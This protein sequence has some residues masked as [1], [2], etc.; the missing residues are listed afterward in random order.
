MYNLNQF[1]NI[2]ALLRK[3]KGWTQTMFAEKLGISPQAISKWECGIGYPDV[4]LFPIIAELL[5]VP[6]GVIF[7]EETQIEEE[8]TMEAQRIV[9][10]YNG[11]FDICSHIKIYLGNICRVELIEGHGEGCRVKAAG[12]PIF[13][14]FFDAEQDG[15]TLLVDVR[16]P[17]G[18]KTRWEVYDRKGYTN[19]NLIQIYTPVF[20]DDLCFE[21]ENYLDLIAE[22]G[23]SEQGNYQVI[24]SVPEE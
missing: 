14:R 4:T 5:E 23:I 20:G 16:N 11:D 21:T 9:T 15:D 17:C 1:C 6:I 7:G 24:C 3:K 2:I 10:E 13:I 8:N 12:D 19:E 18:S 22:N